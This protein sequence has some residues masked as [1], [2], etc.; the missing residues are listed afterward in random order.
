M[1]LDRGVVIDSVKAGK[2]QIEYAAHLTLCNCFCAE[3]IE[4][5]FE[6]TGNWLGMGGSVNVLLFD[7]T[8]LDQ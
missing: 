7:Q 6:G 4:W 8:L 5:L 2:H 3:V 1:G